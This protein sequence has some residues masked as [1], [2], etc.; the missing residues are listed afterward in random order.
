MEVKEVTMEVVIARESIHE[1]VQQAI[2][3]Q[4]TR[5]FDPGF[6]TTATA[7]GPDAAPTTRDSRRGNLSSPAREWMV[8]LDI[9][10]FF[11]HVNHDILSRHSR[12]Q[13]NN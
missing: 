4:L 7:S 9:S 8:D 11:D 5:V 2:S 13:M 1:A 6:Q 3:Q 12:N 10:K